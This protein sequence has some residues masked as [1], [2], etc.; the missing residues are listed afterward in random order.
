[1]NTQYTYIHDRPVIYRGDTLPPM[2]VKLE[3]EDGRKIIP[4][5]VCAQI[6][7]QFGDVVYDYDARLEDG[8]VVLESIPG[9]D[10]AGF[11]IGRLLYDIEY[12]LE[13]GDTHTFIRGSI[14][15]LEDVSRC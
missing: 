6:R 15:I 10:T 2:A 12:R 1:M 5:F 14:H 8:R 13:S 11:P 7:S 9:S 3:H 4:V